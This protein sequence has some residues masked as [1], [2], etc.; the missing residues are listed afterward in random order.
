M[1]R[2]IQKTQEAF[3]GLLYEGF[4]KEEYEMYLRMRARM[5][6]NVSNKKGERRKKHE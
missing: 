2:E 3:L 5:L 6:E 4:S 1:T